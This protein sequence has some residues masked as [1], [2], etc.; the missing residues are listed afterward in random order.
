MTFSSI[1][2]SLFIVYIIKWHNNL[3]IITI[4]TFLHYGKVWETKKTNQLA[5]PNLKVFQ[6]T[7]L[8]VF[9]SEPLISHFCCKVSGLFMVHW[10]PRL[11]A[12]MPPKSHWKCGDKKKQKKN[13]HFPAIIFRPET[14][15]T[16]FPGDMVTTKETNVELTWVGKAGWQINMLGLNF[17]DQWMVSGGNLYV[18]EQKP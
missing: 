13:S 4:K 12:N 15:G 10:E 11:Q 2:S 5:F 18:R 3:I 1:L 17:H 8:R 7:P 6:K 16:W 14:G 9:C